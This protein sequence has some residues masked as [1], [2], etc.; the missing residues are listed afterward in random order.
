MNK[1]MQVQGD[2]TSP[3]TAAKIV[4]FVGEGQCDL[5]LCDGAP[6]VT[7]TPELDEYVSSVYI[8]VYIYMYI[9]IYVYMYICICT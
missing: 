6:D 4:A 7:G 8:Y 1:Y 2:L 9:C 5:V 3:E